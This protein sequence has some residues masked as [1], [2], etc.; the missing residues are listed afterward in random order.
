[1]NAPENP[2]PVRAA[3]AGGDE[4]ALYEIRRK[5][6]PRAVTGVFAQWRWALVV[7]T[8]IVYYGLPWLTWDGRQ[9]VLFDLGARKFYILGLVLW[10][11]DVIYL[12]V[13]LVLCACGAATPAR[14]PSTPRCSCGSS[15]RSR[16]TGWRG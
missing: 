4:I 12:T 8:Q 15:A 1:M 16:A 11:Q 2:V 10:P 14:R 7:L 3:K 13:I 5:I 9:A 6:Y